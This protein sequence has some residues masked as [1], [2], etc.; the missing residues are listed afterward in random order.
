[1]PV[2][3]TALAEGVIPMIW[4]ARLKPLVPVA[5]ALILATAGVAVQGRQQPAPEGAREQARTAPP[6]AAGAGG[7]AV[8]DLAANR[9]IARQQV[10]LIDEAEATLRQLARHGKMDIAD[11]SFSLWGSRRLEALRRA[12]AGKAE[13]VAAL[14]KYI[15][16]LKEDEA[17]AESLKQ[18]ARGTQ[19]TVYDIQFRR[20]EAEIWLNEE[21][22]R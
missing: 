9:D 1:V 18:S 20:M 10:A 6:T 7:A 8:P 5:A 19:L 13:I 22:A 12:G 3:V 16:I 14:E 15:A 11:S 17:L 4:L 21:R 2:A